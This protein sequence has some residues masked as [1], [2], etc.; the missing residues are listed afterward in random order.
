MRR[1]QAL[2]ILP[3]EELQ[4]TKQTQPAALEAGDASFQESFSFKLSAMQLADA[5]VRHTQDR[6]TSAGRRCALTPPSLC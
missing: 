1:S 4:T 5:K 3:D 6:F 2:H